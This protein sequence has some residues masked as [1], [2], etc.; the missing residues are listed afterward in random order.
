MPKWPNRL[1]QP[2]VNHLRCS[3]LIVKIAFDFQTVYEVTNWPSPEAMID[4]YRLLYLAEHNKWRM[5][6]WLKP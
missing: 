5:T 3:V 1:V 6:Y 4:L 2:P